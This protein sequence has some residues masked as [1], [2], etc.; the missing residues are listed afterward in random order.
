MTQLATLLAIAIALLTLTPTP[1]NPQAHGDH[2][3]VTAADLKWADV[4][5]LP[6]GAKIAVI[7]GPM[8]EAKPF[9]MRLR[10]PA[11]YQIPAHFH[12]AIEH[13]TVVSGTFNMGA[14]DK[15]DTKATRALEPG[16]VAIMQPGTRHFAWT[17]TETVVQVHG[18][19]PWTVTYV[20]PADD[21]R[22]K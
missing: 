13:V 20:N 8:N 17:K 6:P 10:L 4:P 12:T 21:P 7:E 5:S 18:V 16:S 11:N 19:G 2:L 9:T 15:L 14:G 1:G 22:K 3:M